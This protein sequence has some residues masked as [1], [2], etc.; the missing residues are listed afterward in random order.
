MQRHRRGRRV[1][2]QVDVAG[3]DVVDG[4]AEA[5]IRDVHG[6]DVGEHIELHGREVP[7]R[8][9]ARGRGGDLSRIGLGARDQ[10]LHGRA[11]EALAQHQHV[12]SG[13]QQRDRR[14]ARRI[15]GHVLVE[16]AV[17]G[18]RA[19]RGEQE[20]VAVGRRARHLGRADI[21]G[22]AADVLHDR[23]LSPFAAELVGDQACQR[24]GAAAGRV[25]HDDP[26]Q[27]RRERLLRA[28]R[29]ERKYGGDR[30]QCHQTNCDPSHRCSPALKEL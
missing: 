10:V 20:R 8:A 3:D 29:L 21:A 5:A 15:V 18:D 19:G 23:R 30:G 6:L 16:E 13:R 25:G 2:H 17:G 4:G 1:E 24:I 28:T 7:D 22:R 12:G 27:P 14:P 9:D 26:H 11:V